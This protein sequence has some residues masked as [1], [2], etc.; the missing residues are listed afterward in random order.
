VVMP[1]LAGDGCDAGEVGE[2]G[3]V[4][5]AVRVRP[6]AEHDRGD[7]GADTEGREEIWPP[8]DDDGADGGF[9]IPGFCLEVQAASGQGAQRVRG[10]GGL[11]VLVGLGAEPGCRGQH[12]PGALASELGSQRFGSCGNQSV[13]LALRQGGAL[14]SGTADGKAPGESASLGAC[15]GL[16]EV[17][18]SQSFA[19]SADSVE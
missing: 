8:R 5:A 14:D 19:G 1:L 17:G 6:G 15:S 2:G 4:A 16:C 18:A 7:D 3:V 11:D 9:V 13:E 12:G 10:G